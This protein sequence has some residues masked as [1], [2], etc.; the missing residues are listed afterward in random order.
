[1][2]VLLLL[3]PTRCNYLDIHELFTYAALEVLSFWTSSCVAETLALA[4]LV[5]P[6]IEILEFDLQAFPSA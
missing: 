4:L 3:A 2:L 6:T 1:M 5:Y